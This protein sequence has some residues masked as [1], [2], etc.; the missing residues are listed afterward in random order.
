MSLIRKTAA[1]KRSG[2]LTYVL[3]DA[4]LDRYGDIIEPAGWQLEWFRKNPIA[5]F[6]HSAMQPIGTWRDIRVEDGRLI[7]ELEPA[8]RGTS[9][10]VDEI[11]SLIEQDILRATSVGFR[12]IQSEPID[13][14]HPYN[15]TRYTEQELLETSVVSVPAN[16]AALQ[17]AKSL[18][19]SDETLTLAF[20]GQAVMKRR[21]MATTGGQAVTQRLSRAGLP[22]TIAQQIQDTQERLNAARDALTEHVRDTDHDVDQAALLQNEIEAHEQRLGSL[23]R[24]ERALAARAAQQQPSPA[25]PELP[26]RR[27]L[28][29]PAKEIEPRELLWRAAAVHFI[30]KVTQRPVDD[31]LRER[32]P[33][34]EATAVVTRAAMTGATTTVAGWAA[35][36]VQTAY[37]DFLATLLPASVFPRLAALGVGLTF[38]PQGGAIKIPSRAT[39][40]SI[41]G[42]FVAEGA[43][44]PVR[45]LGT[46]SITLLPHKVGALSVFSREIAQYSNPAIEG[47]IREGISDDTAIN[48]DGLLIDNVASS[49]TRPAGLTNGVTPLTASTA[50]GYTA[51]LADLQALTAPFFAVNAGRKLAL[52]MSKAQGQQLMFA[53]GPTGVPFGWTTQ[54]TDRYAVIESTS[55][56]AGE[57]LMVD[58]A[59]FVSVNGSAE[60]EVSE[61]ATLHMEDTTPLNIGTAGS[62]ATVAAPT[63]SMFQT[64]QIAIRMLANVTWAMRRANM[65]QFMTG[66]NWGP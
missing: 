49:A 37:A 38:G 27:P 2:S 35:E 53:P 60:F 28:G 56:P 63:Q 50:H 19:I 5:L 32:Y 4:T 58:A 3:S 46:T 10:R 6:N 25:H 22:M 40:P 18:N 34:H 17:I 52:M 44:I 42:S 51:I 31:V 12:S 36:L 16:P 29:I 43:P 55:I 1:G 9:Q 54:F 61:V 11:L 39:T 14:K 64:A 20:G 7:A 45:R 26:G 62:P 15:G 24:T 8:E 21:G 41:G 48:I 13:P 23:E 33:D 57:V 65:V 47:I 66:V 30:S 59:D